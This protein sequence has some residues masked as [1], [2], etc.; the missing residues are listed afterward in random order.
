MIKDVDRESER[1]IY[2]AIHDAKLARQNDKGQNEVAVRTARWMDGAGHD[3][4][5]CAIGRSVRRRRRLPEILERKLVLS[6]GPI[7]QRP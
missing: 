2:C 3:A 1:V 5:G 7:S 6:L 4:V